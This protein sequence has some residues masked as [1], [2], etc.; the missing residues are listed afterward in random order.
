MKFL[1]AIV[2][3]ASLPGCANYT[4]K[5]FEYGDRVI[6][7]SGFYR[8]EKGIVIDYSGWDR[9]YNRDRSRN[10]YQ[11]RF[12]RLNDLTWVK[13]NELALFSEPPLIDAPTFSS[14]DPKEESDDAVHKGN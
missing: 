8:G 9:S 14:P 4:P 6:A 11:V 10:K 12:D 3:L 5:Y 2:L 13:E 1:V 7:T